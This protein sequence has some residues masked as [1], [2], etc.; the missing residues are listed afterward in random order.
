MSD[1]LVL[2]CF[3]KLTAGLSEVH[4]KQLLELGVNNLQPEGHIQPAKPLD[5]PQ[6]AVILAGKHWGFGGMEALS[7]LV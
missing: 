3:L 7:E 2:G 4:T 5:L 6:G 1:C